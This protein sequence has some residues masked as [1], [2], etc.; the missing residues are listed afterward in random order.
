[1]LF[2]F[3][4]LLVTAIIVIK[5]ILV[6]DVYKS[7]GEKRVLKG[8]NFEVRAGDSV[9][10]L[11]GSGSGKTVLFKI[12]STLMSPDEGSVL[13]DDMDITNLTERQKEQLMEQFGFAFQLNALFDSYTIW[14]NIGFRLINNTKISR[15]EIKEIAIA[16]LKEVDLDPSVADLKPSNISGGMQ[17]RVAVARALVGSPSVL[18]FD[19]PTSGLDPLTSRKIGDLIRDCDKNFP[20]PLIKFSIVHDIEIARLIATKIIFLY[21]G[22]IEWIGS[23]KEMDLA[24]NKPFQEFINAGA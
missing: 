20:E 12:L 14:E 22:K 18:F 2:Y 9:V 21:Q 1:M 7:F 23:V 17:K 5:K 11:G 16:K 24:D 6:K 3:I 19:E 15:K 4:S 13:M 10:I 8:I